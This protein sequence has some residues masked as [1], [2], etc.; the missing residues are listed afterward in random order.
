MIKVLR[1][2]FKKFFREFLLYHNNSLEYRAKVF[3]LVIAANEHIHPCEEE[4]LMECACA[5]YKN[6]EERCEILVE[7]VKEYYEK[8]ITNNGLDFEHLVFQVEK[9][10]RDVKRFSA[11]I[12]V[13]ALL[14]FQACEMTADE[15][16]YQLR[17][18]E[19]LADLKARYT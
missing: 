10:T 11:K 1:R 18:I 19:F 2:K 6:D 14:K 12:D 13:D 4:L 17:V 15:K 8:I 7:T 5:I 3:T 9:E 16:L